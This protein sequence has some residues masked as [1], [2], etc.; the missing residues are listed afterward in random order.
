LPFQDPAKLTKLG[1]FGM[2]IYHLATL[3]YTLSQSRWRKKQENESSH[4]LIFKASQG[5]VLPRVARWHIFKPK[6][7]IWVN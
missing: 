3:F 4:D 7:S 1:I 6:I 2:K 5:R